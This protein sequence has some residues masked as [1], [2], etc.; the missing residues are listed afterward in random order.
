MNEQVCLL[1]CSFITSPSHISCTFRLARVALKALSMP[2]AEI[3]RLAE[4]AL[5]TEFPPQVQMAR[6]ERTW[7]RLHSCS[8]KQVGEGEGAVWG[9]FS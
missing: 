9:D 2:A 4:A 6:Y 3:R 5:R 8:R 7:A 1:G